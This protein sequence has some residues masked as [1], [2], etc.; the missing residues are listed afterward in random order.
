MAI[1]SFAIN[2]ASALS[3]YSAASQQADAQNKAYGENADAAV[4][5]Q[6][7]QGVQMNL[8]LQ[9]EREAATEEKTDASREVRSAIETARMTAGEAGVGGVSTRALLAEYMGR[10]GS[11]NA[12]VD[13]Q[14][15]ANKN[16]VALNLRGLKSQATDRIRSI[17]RAPKP[18]FLPTALRIGGAGL[19]AYSTYKDDK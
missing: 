12:G 6:I 8:R 5:S 19:D 2:G 11:V 13:R 10:L 4:K 9:Q 17:N 3:E 15:D 1:S 16:Q 14:Y 7:E 18:S